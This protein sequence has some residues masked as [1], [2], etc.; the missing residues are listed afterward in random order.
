MVSIGVIIL[1]VGV[2]ANQ[3]MWV[4]VS[5]WRELLC[6]GV[7]PPQA[8]RL[9]LGKSKVVLFWIVLATAISHGILYVPQSMQM[10]LNSLQSPCLVF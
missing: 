6:C 10:T 9:S 2:S 5:E 3:V 4:P 8:P 7:E 1:T